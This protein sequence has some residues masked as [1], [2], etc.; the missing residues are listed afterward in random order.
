MAIGYEP[1]RE[2]SGIIDDL[3][4]TDHGK[5]VMLA[6]RPEIQSADNFNTNCPGYTDSATLGC[7]YMQRIF[8]YDVQN[9]ELDGI[10]QAVTAHE[11]LHAVW[12]RMGENQRQEIAD[13]LQ[14]VYKENIDQLKSH[15]EIYSDDEQLDELHSVIGTEVS[16]SKYTTKLKKHYDEFF[17]D[18]QAVHAYYEKYSEKF[19]AIQKRNEE[20]DKLIK[21]NQAKLE[22][23]TDTYLSKFN[24]LNDDIDAFNDKNAEGGFTSQYEFYT[25][26]NAL[27]ARRDALQKDY[28]AIIALTNQINEY[29]NE[30]NQNLTRSNQLYD[31]VNSRVKKPDNL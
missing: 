6:S 20:L 30:Y 22:S 4:L 16:P 31:S 12:A 28:D 14:K 23:D 19:L 9:A 24:Q 11:L 1:T 3:K 26:R 5:R 18:H 10:K 25:E 15:M 8:V 2:M 21:E 29:I 13:D 7:Y 17:T 27:L